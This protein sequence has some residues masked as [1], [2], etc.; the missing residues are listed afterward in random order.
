MLSV[1][2]SATVIRGDRWHHIESLSDAQKK[3]LERLTRRA[4]KLHGKLEDFEQIS[5]NIAR[6][7]K[8]DTRPH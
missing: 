2:V 4:L 8:Y 5:A 7:D 1:P 3:Y 6:Y